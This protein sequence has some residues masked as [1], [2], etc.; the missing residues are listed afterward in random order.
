MEKKY[1]YVFFEKQTDRKIASRHLSESEKMDITKQLESSVSTITFPMD[2][3]ESGF[4]MRESIFATICAEVKE[5]VKEEKP[6]ISEIKESD[7]S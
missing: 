3:M 2:N 5:E 6:V 7:L 4:V 1:V